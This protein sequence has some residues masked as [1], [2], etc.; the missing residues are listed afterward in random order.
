MLV[1]VRYNISAETTVRVGV[2]SVAV[3]TLVA[4]PMVPK[5]LFTSK[6]VE[7]PARVSNP[8]SVQADGGSSAGGVHWHGMSGY[9]VAGRQLPV[10]WKRT[11]GQLAVRGRRATRATS[12]TRAGRA[13]AARH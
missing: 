2:K 12:A 1:R 10:S 3:D 5:L 9:N 4:G 6:M 13:P 7:V 11:I 8:H